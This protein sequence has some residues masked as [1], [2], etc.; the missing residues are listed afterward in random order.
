LLKKQCFNYQNYS[1]FVEKPQEKILE[2]EIGQAVK[3]ARDICADRGHSD[4]ECKDAWNL[5][6]ELEAEAA[7]QQAKKP[8][9]R[10]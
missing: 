5:V 2:E 4:K 3:N 8:E 6:E 9:K 10:L 1:D 7:Y